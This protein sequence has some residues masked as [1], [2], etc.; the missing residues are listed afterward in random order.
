MNFFARV[1][2]VHRPMVETARALI[3]TSIHELMEPTFCVGHDPNFIG[4]HSF[5]VEDLVRSAPEY[6][7]AGSYGDMA[8]AM[9]EEQIIV[10]PRPGLYAGSEVG[11]LLHEW[12]HLFDHVTGRSLDAPITTSYSKTNRS[13]RIAEAFEM[14]LSP[15]SGAWELYTRSEAFRPLREAMGI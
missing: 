3:P 1:P 9:C 12:G 14:V 15:T 6:T 8:H 7:K 11:T 13:E 5:T 10:F 2:M 4:L